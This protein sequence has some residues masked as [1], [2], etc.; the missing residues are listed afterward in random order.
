[1]RARMIGVTLFSMFVIFPA[2]SL[3][4]FASRMNLTCQSCHINPTGAGL[5][6]QFGV[7]YGQEDLP[8]PTWQEEYSLEGFSNQLNDFITIGANFRTLFFS[9]QTPLA[10]RISFFQMQS[11]LYVSARIAKR[12][13]FYLNRGNAGRFEAFGLAGILPE[14]GYVKVG[15]FVPDFGV[16]VDDHNV[17]TRD[18]TLFAFGG[19]HDAGLEV[20]FFPGIFAFTAAVTNGAAADRDNNQAKAL[21]GK[22]EIRLNFASINLRAGGSYYNNAGSNGVTTLLGVHAIASLRGNLTLFGEFVQ[23][24]DFSNATQIKTFSNILSVGA[25]Y[26]LT[27]GLDLKIG[28]EFYDPDTKYKT[29]TE[30]RIVFGFEFYPIGGIELRPLYVIRKEEPTD[31]KNDQM[32]LLMHVYL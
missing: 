30:S 20:G 24:R 10:A 13:F 26:V 11:D 15:W 1:M 21:T 6:N 17:F 27:P 32:I 14:R 18:K 3:P 28:F 19:G 16:R 2:A 12:T 9:Q 25:D 4:K 7:S 22:G 29:G 8:I 5:R 31:T 23:R